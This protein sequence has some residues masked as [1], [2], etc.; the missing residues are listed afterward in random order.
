MK[1]LKAR[2][3]LLTSALLSDGLRG[4]SKHTVLVWVGP[5]VLKND[6]AFKLRLKTI[7]CPGNGVIL[8]TGYQRLCGR[9]GLLTN[10]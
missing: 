9:K 5:V 8:D 10:Q 2:Y 4:A 6:S 1:Q 7:G 3:L